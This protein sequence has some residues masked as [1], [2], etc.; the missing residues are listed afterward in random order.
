MPLHWHCWMLSDVSRYSQSGQRWKNLSF[1]LSIVVFK[2]LLTS[3][4]LHSSSADNYS[5]C[6]VTKIVRVDF[7]E[8]IQFLTGVTMSVFDIS[9]THSFVENTGDKRETMIFNNEG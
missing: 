5:L 4:C 7:G 8:H 9:I 3:G 6:S 1:H 2:S